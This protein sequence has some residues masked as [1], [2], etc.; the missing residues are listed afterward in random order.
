MRYNNIQKGDRRDCMS[1]PEWS[2][3]FSIHNEMIDMQHKKLFQI[4]HKAGLL[5]YKQVDVGEIRKILAEL[6]DYMKEHFHDEEAYMEQI[7]YP[8]IERHK[9]L[10]KE[11]IA[12]MCDLIQNIKYDFKQKLAIITEQWL[13]THILK[14]D[15]RI[16]QYRAENEQ[17][18]QDLLNSQEVVHVYKCKCKDSFNVLNT[19]HEKIQNGQKFHCKKCG[20][21]IEFIVD[22]AK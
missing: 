20:A 3:E 15:M 10:H 5:I 8:D 13:I 7:K 4:A 11:I 14:E 18:I 2:E 12:N 16:E 1:L 19:I 9:K 6:F 22:K 21:T 17:R